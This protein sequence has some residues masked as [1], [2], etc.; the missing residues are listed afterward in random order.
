MAS[1]GDVSSFESRGTSLEERFLAQYK[2][3]SL[4]PWPVHMKEKWIEKTGK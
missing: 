1:T 3:E 4:P 2:A